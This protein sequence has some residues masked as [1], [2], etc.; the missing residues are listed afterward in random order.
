M[1]RLIAMF[2]SMVMLVGIIPCLAGTGLAA[3]ADDVYVPVSIW[4]LRDGEEIIIVSEDRSGAFTEP[5]GLGNSASYIYLQ[6]V[7]IID[8]KIVDPSPEILWEFDRIDEGVNY[9]KCA[10]YHNGKALAKASAYEW[11]E[12]GCNPDIDL[13]L[14]ASY[15]FFLMD[16]LYPLW[17]L[18]VSPNSI[19]KCRI[20]NA[21]KNGEISLFD[22]YYGSMMSGGRTNYVIGCGAYT[23]GPE[24]FDFVIYAKRDASYDPER[25]SY[26]TMGHTLNLESDISL[27]L[28]V[29]KQVI[30]K[31]EIDTEY[32]AMDYTLTDTVGG[33]TTERS[34]YITDYEEYGDYFVFTIGG[35]TAVDMNAEIK[36]KLV[37]YTYGDAMIGGDEAAEVL[38]TDVYSIATY[39][40]S[41]M[42][43][44]DA[45]AELKTVCA[46]LLRYGAKA[47]IFKGYRAEELVD[48]NM[49]EVH[50]SHLS[51]MD[52]VTFGTMDLILDDLAD[53]PITW[54]GKSLNLESK[55]A[56]KFAFDPSVYGGAI[57]A[58][59]LKVRYTDIKGE[60]KTATVADP[61][62]YN[63]E[64]GLYTFTFD[65]LLATELRSVVSVQI[66]NGEEAVS[67]TL[68]YSADTYGNDRTGD[69]LELCKALFAYSDSAKIFFD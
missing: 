56:L 23:K 49:T 12:P 46:D 29:K 18:K 9:V 28:W 25:P 34:G 30:V 60:E 47:Q 31:N 59:T 69:L 4:D 13:P 5:Y 33:N 6:D 10:F 68:Q 51:D 41:Q 21:Q 43:K 19:F 54:V 63:E 65:G 8:G 58:L 24:Y 61:E 14:D 3:Q 50:K 66:Y 7:E 40:Y 22:S 32:M 64:K 16:G 38:Y 48:A 52:A 15:D 26:M 1:K 62:L 55:V 20:S 37:A 17:K 39:A 42:N 35:L 36:S 45:S 44:Q 11:P 67:A 2:L 53:A 27:K 57:S